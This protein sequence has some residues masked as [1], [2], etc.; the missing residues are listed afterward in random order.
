[1][2]ILGDISNKYHNQ[3]TLK[4][5]NQYLKEAGLKQEN[6]ESLRTLI[7]R[8]SQLPKDDEVYLL[9][10][11]L[12][13]GET[14]LTAV[15][16]N[17]YFDKEVVTN[18]SDEDYYLSN[19]DLDDI[20][21]LKNQ[22]LHKSGNIPWA[23]IQR[24]LKPKGIVFKAT[25]AVLKQLDNREATLAGLPLIVG[26][27]SLDLDSFEQ[28]EAKLDYHTRQLQN[29]KRDYNKLRRE[30]N[31]DLLFRKQLINAIPKHI[32]C[33][34]V[35]PN[36][37]YEENNVLVVFLSDLHIGLKTEDYN[38]SI[39]EQRLSDYVD[40]IKLEL[41]TH[42]ISRIE[43]I[44]L[45]D[46]IEGAYLHATQLYE[47][48]FGF[49][50]QVAK[51]LELT[52]SF[53]ESVQAMH[54][55]VSFTAISGNHD[56]ANEANKKDNLAGDS[57]VDIIN[58]TVQLHAKELGITFNKP[59]TKCRHLLQVN[60]TNIACVHGDLDRLASPNLMSKLSSYFNHKVDTV[61]GGHL[62]SFSMTSLGLNQYVVQSSSAFNGN[63]YSDALGV[64]ATPG[65]VMLLVS[66]DGTINP[67]LVIF[68]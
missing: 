66:E 28:D 16:D 27:H 38:V 56:R 35:E 31:D 32:D 57:I 21:E 39:L 67:K 10:E 18:D 59:T 5:Y 33:N 26:K 37:T 34:P 45:G 36:V 29:A 44:G 53:I 20:I 4:V 7:K 60:N 61:V 30:L 25:P 47:L 23:T 19:H 12:K 62:H 1:M 64:K 68:K 9:Y 2:A 43:I 8:L 58:S 54:K 24:L 22:Y 17:N 14:S 13:S 40:Q 50:E 15:M 51:A 6:L 3:V 65:Q 52:L 55:P 11:G 46:F 63:S 49:G 41:L 42:K 48:E